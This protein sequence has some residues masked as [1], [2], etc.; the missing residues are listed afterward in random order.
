MRV[1]L[2][3][4][5]EAGAFA[6]MLINVGDGKAKNIVQQPDTVRTTELANYATSV[7][8]LI[9]KVFPNFQENVVDND[10]LS[11]QGIL[12]SLNEPALNVLSR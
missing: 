1:H 11:K 6:E 10:W 8:D 7:D 3:G 9:D 5:R 2:H 12:A 4:D